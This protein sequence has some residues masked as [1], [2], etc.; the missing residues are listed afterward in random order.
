MINLLGQE[1][2]HVKMK[3]DPYF[4]PHAKIKFQVD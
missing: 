3:I 4:I 2:S 1:A